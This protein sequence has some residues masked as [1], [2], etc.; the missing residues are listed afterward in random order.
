LR[1]H[2]AVSAYRSDLLIASGEQDLARVAAG[3]V[4]DEAPGH[5]PALL[6]NLELA[7]ADGRQ[8]EFE[9][10]LSKLATVLENSAFGA[11]IN[12][13]RGVIAE[14][15]SDRDAA[16]AAYRKAIQTDA[17]GRPAYSG[18]ARTLLRAEKWQEAAT[19]LH[20]VASATG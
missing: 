11:A 3:E 18:L 13:V 8:D 4:L 20:H 16:L 17:A 5:I 6:A 19:V 10:S 1:E 14:G 12:T 15:R 2:R 9:D 7:F